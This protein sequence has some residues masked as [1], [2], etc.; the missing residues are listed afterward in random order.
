MVE[1]NSKLCKRIKRYRK[2]DVIYNCGIVDNSIFDG[3]RGK[4]TYYKMDAHTLNSFSIEDVKEYER[5]GHKL[6]ATEDISVI[7]INEIFKK[8]GK[9]DFLSIDIE[10]LDFQILKSLDYEKYAPLCMCVET[11]EY[12]GI[13]RSDFNEIN[14]F[15]KNK[16]YMIYADTSLNTIYVKEKEFLENLKQKV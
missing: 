5:F 9:V 14:L 11:R 16:G 1:P 7:T 12:N 8:N 13:K 6:V 15:L 2:K 4:L 3:G 10:G